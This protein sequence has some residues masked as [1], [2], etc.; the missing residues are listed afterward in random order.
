MSEAEKLKESSQVPDWGEGVT[1]KPPPPDKVA[2]RSLD[3]KDFKYLVR[4]FSASS[5]DSTYLPSF[6]KDL[7]PP[8]P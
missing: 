1:F 6:G 2:E 7:A 3:H 8:C 5:W 4:P